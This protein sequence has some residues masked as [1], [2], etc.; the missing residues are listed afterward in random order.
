MRAQSNAYRLLHVDQIPILRV[1]AL[2][3]L[4][5]RLVVCVQLTYPLCM[6]RHQLLRAKQ[7]ISMF[8][9]LRM[10]LERQSSSM[11]VLCADMLC[12]MSQ[13][14]QTPSSGTNK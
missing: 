2:K 14:K 10:S 1:Q 7:E 5:Q 12:S 4:P 8:A 11:P 13:S 3:S 9:F 6:R